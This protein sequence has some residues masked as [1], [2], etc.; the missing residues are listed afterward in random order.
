M[1]ETYARHMYWFRD[2]YIRHYSP[3]ASSAAKVV[4]PQPLQQCNEMTS[5]SHCVLQV[6]TKE[7][8][9]IDSLRPFQS[10]GAYHCIYND[11]TVLAVPRKTADGKTMIVQLTSL[12]R[13]GISLFLEPLLRLASNQ[14][15]RSSVP[16]HNMEAYHCDEL[17]QQDRQLL[18]DWL[19]S[20]NTDR[21]EA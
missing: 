16:D 15:D 2:A 21:E 18:V 14:V 8:F 3:A 20:Y 13:R 4:D 7:V 11:N 5:N 1:N 17:K 9:G 12:L 10:V 6:A 19:R